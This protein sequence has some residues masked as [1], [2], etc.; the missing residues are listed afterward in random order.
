VLPVLLLLLLLAPSWSLELPNTHHIVHGNTP[1]PS[2]ATYMPHTAIM[3]Y[4]LLLALALSGVFIVYK[5]SL[6]G[7]REVR[8]EN[9]IPM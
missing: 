3:C 2:N 9:M 7:L 1:M 4:V 6:R 8:S 5:E